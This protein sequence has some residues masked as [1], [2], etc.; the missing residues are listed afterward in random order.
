MS[1]TELELTFHDTVPLDEKDL[2]EAHEKALKQKLLVLDVFKRFKALNFTPVEVHEYLRDVQ[3]EPMLL[4]SVRRSI[5]D[6]TKEGKL[7][8]CMWSESRPGKYGKLN[9]VWQYNTL[10]DDFEPLNPK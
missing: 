8:K 6:L 9:R 5:S 1:V 3:N 7:V 2:P 4:T 10:R